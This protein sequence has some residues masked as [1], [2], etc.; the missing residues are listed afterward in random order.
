VLQEALAAGHRPEFAVRVEAEG[1]PEIERLA[2]A[3]LDAGSTVDEVDARTFRALSA[4]ETPQP[5]LAV[6]G[7]PPPPGPRVREE[8]DRVLVLDAVQD[9]G[10]VGT[11]VRSAWAFGVG[12]VVALDGTADPW[13]AKVVRASAGAGFR[14]P[15]I[16]ESWSACSEWIRGGGRRV[17]VGVAGG[18]PVGHLPDSERWAVVVGNEAEG[19]RRE[20]ADAADAAVAIPMARGVD[21]LNVAVAGSILLYALTRSD[22]DPARGDGKEDRE[23]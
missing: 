6:F 22:G 2:Q 15:V 7:E 19:P 4:T 13:S 8:A 11:L 1:G 18:Q 14:V 21:S 12:L 10:N 9:P 17:L 16:R 23:S 3:I 20:V 5:I